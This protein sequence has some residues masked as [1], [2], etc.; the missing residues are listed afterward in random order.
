MPFECEDRVAVVRL[1]EVEQRVQPHLIQRCRADPP[2]LQDFPDVRGISPADHRP[3]GKVFSISPAGASADGEF[4]GK[5]LS[6]KIPEAVNVEFDSEEPSYIFFPDGSG[7]GT[8]FRLTFKGH[9]F[10]IRISGLTGVAIVE[11][12]D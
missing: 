10:H 4:S 2:H 7:S 1:S 9:A 8:S 11:K 12:V 5:F 3:G 6:E